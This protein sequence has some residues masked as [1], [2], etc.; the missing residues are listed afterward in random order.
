MDKS[1]ISTAAI[2]AAAG[3]LIGAGAAALI[4][5]QRG[6]QIRH[7]V[8]DAVDALRETGPQVNEKVHALAEK[9]QDVTGVV[10]ETLGAV[11]ELKDE[12]ASVARDV[13]SNVQESVKSSSNSTDY[14]E[15]MQT[16]AAAGNAAAPNKP[17]DGSA[18]SI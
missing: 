18:G 3:A 9:S 13:K 17:K 11:K 14:N 2:G 1:F 8:L 15:A 4:S 5:T 16:P 7:T 12:T 10:K 6:E